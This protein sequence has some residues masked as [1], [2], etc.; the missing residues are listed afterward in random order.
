[1][2]GFQSTRQH[3][4]PTTTA[5]QGGATGPAAALAIDY[6]RRVLQLDRVR[7]AQSINRRRLMH[8]FEFAMWALR[9]HTGTKPP[10]AWTLR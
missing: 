2:M 6:E 10:T 7:V 5:G 3:F 8:K 4:E 9:I 1:M